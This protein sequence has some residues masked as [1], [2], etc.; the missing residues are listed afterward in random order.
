MNQKSAKNSNMHDRTKR[1]TTR[2]IQQDGKGNI[3]IN[4][5]K[6]NE[7]EMKHPHEE[8]HIYIYAFYI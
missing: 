4:I 7:F 1:N 6:D 8:I 2:E 3:F 5:H